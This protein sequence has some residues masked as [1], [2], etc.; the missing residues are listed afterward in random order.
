MSEGPGGFFWSIATFSSR[1]LSFVVYSP[2]QSSPPSAA[3][4][5]AVPATMANIP[6]DPRPFV[7]RGFQI[8]EVPGRVAIKRVVVP[9]RQQQHEDIAIA[10]IN[11][12]PPG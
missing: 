1:L 2:F 8:L 9:R 6:I 3:A 4:A 11:P 12:V 5:A 10:T 7:P